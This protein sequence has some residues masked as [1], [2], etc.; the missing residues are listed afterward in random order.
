MPRIIGS[1]IHRN[2]KLNMDE[3]M[4]T[5][6]KRPQ[7]RPEFKEIYMSYMRN[8]VLITL[9]VDMDG[10][11]LFADYPEL[12]EIKEHIRRYCDDS[13]VGLWAFDSKVNPTAINDPATGR[14]RAD[15]D[16]VEWRLSVFFEHENDLEMFM[17]EEA[18]LLKLSI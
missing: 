18:L 17:K 11:R 9:T 14:S 10:Q 2:R 16:I 5:E 8:R 15:Y 12:D 13:C 3:I 6:D 7:L 1:K 4:Q